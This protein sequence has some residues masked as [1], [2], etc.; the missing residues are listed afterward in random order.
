[1]KFP[2]KEEARGESREEGKKRSIDIVDLD[3]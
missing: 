1:M 2:R 3:C